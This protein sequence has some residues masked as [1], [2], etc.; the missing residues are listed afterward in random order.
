MV[1]QRVTVTTLSL[2]AVLPGAT[3]VPG[4]RVTGTT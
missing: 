3:P 1:R 4:L 2:L